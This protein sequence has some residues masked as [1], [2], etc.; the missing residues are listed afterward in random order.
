LVPT[1]FLARRKVDLAT[2]ATVTALLALTAS[3]GTLDVRQLT[4]GGRTMTSAV[5]V[6]EVNLTAFFAERVD[7]VSP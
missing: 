1:L 3:S 6:T 2:M 7:Y 4:G 5:F